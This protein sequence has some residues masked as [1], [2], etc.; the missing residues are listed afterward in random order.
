MIPAQWK[1]ARMYAEGNGVD[2]V[3]PQG[4]RVLQPHRRH[5]CRRQSRHAAVAHHRQRLRVARPLL[6]RRHRRPRDQRPIGAAAQQ[7]YS[8]RGVLLRMPVR[9]GKVSSRR[10]LLLDGDPQQNPL[11]PRA[12]R[13]PPRTSSR[14]H[15]Q[16][17]LGRLLFQGDDRPARAI[18]HAGLMVARSRATTPTPS[19]ESPD[20]RPL[21]VRLQRRRPKTKHALASDYL[22]A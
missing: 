7:M 20:R 2:P 14:Y 16:A 10:M 21:S 9:S 17:V 13:T 15:A 1:L 19:E 5:A 6:P 8:W 11:Q 4:V 18:P 22:R 3:G 12:V